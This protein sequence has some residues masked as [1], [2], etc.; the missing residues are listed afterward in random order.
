MANVIE[1][2]KIALEMERKGYQLYTE[3]A[4]KTNNKLGKATLE[5]I[6]AKEIDHIKNIEAY[7]Q[8]PAE[9]VLT[10]RTNLREI[11]HREK[12][13][14]IRDIIDK[15]GAQLE[16]LIKADSNLLEIYKL[17][18]DLER[19]SY[20]FYQKLKEETD[21]K[22]TDLKDFLGFLMKEENNHYEILQETLQY[23]DHPGDWFREQER[24]IVEG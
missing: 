13:D 16:E 12:I 1:A 18:M 19:E 4:A 9:G 22:A 21:E 7:C 3:A 23:L 20:D 6:A 2:M 8:K 17:A 24:W 15:T 10:I 5:A 11:S 14:Y